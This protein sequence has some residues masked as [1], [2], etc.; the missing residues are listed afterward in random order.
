MTVRVI[1]ASLGS[2][3]EV[4]VLDLPPLMR[5]FRV[6]LLS[7]LKASTLDLDETGE[8]RREELYRGQ[9]RGFTTWYTNFIS[10][11]VVVFEPI[12]RRWIFREARTELRDRAYLIQ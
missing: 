10:T 12:F 3:V 6:S 5:S 9:P 4:M 7:C 11:F 1:L 8:S 2:L